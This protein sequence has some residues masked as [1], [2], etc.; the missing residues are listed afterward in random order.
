MH[1]DCIDLFTLK[2]LFHKMKEPWSGSN[3]AQVAKMSLLLSMQTKTEQDLLKRF[4]APFLILQ[5]IL[6]E[7]GFLPGLP[8]KCLHGSEI[9]N[10]QVWDKPTIKVENEI[11]WKLDPE[12]CPGNKTIISR[13]VICIIC[14]HFSG[15]ALCPINQEQRKCLQWRSSL[16]G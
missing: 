14:L 4:F 10:Q 12:W 6:K 5:N 9:T 15:R 3:G 7:N 13:W 16:E 1:W 8:F 2:Q 11:Y